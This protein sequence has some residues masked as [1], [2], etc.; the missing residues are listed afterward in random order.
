[1]NQ[2]SV[3]Q[4]VQLVKEMRACQLKFDAAHS[5]LNSD[6]KNQERLDLGKKVDKAIKDREKRLF[7][8]E[9]AEQG[10]LF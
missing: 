6:P 1:M 3:N 2:M 7:L 4:F 8:D 5:Y 9:D 10:T